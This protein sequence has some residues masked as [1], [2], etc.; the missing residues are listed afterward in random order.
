MAN[1]TK[2]FYYLRLCIAQGHTVTA[3]SVTSSLLSMCRCV[4][5]RRVSTLEVL[6]LYLL[7]TNELSGTV[8]SGIS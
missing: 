6:K 1:V 3:V 2:I 5:K 4:T 8:Q 7:R